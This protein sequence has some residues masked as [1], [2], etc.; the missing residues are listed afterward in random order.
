[1]PAARHLSWPPS[2][3]PASHVQPRLPGPRPATIPDCCWSQPAAEQ[4][5][6]T[7]ARPLQRQV[8]CGAEL[9]AGWTAAAAAQA[10]GDVD[11]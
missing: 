1:M 6:N 4:Y 3:G 5:G 7:G 8:Y 10:R 11:P 2:S 9:S